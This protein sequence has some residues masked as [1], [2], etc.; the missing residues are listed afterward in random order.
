MGKLRNQGLE[1]SLGYDVIK[2][3]N[4]TWNINA[5][6]TGNKSK[7]VAL[8]G[9]DQ[10]IQGIS[11]NKVGQPLN[12]IYLVRYAGVNPVNGE[13][14]YVTRDGKITETYDPNDAVIVGQFDPKGFGG[15]GTSLSVKGFELSVLFN[16]QYGHKVYNNGRADVENPQ[17]WYSGLSRAML[18]EWKQPGDITDIPSAFSD[19]Q[20][21]T[22]RFVESGDF[23]RLRNVMLSYSLPKTLTDRLKLTGI[24][25][26]IQGQNL[27]TW[28]NF[29]G[30]DPEVATGALTGAQY[31]ALRAFTGG[32]SVGF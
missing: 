4:L 6:W 14:Q 22:S 5:N 29:Q 23:L 31:P 20:Y 17:Y 9:N 8:D 12:S 28:H 7:I 21:S 2:S 24:R 13:A 25:F 16:Y 32:I 3:R 11:I 30:Y 15:F 18:R 26:F 10:N 1:I 27:Y 19:F